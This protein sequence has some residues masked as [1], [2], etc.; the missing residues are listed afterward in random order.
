MF[1]T[2]EFIKYLENML[3]DSQQND[4]FALLIILE[5]IF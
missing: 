2:I 1:I 5:K 4:H 3:N